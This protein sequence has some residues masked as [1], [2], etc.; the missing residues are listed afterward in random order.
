MAVFSK[1]TIVFF[2]TDQTSCPYLTR[3][4]PPSFD[5]GPQNGVLCGSQQR[6]INEELWPGQGLNPG[7]PNDTP[8]L[9]PQLHELMLNGLLL[10]NANNF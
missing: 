9:Y 1:Q 10:V 8:A 4:L 5:T 3:S 6:Q 2:I 7:L